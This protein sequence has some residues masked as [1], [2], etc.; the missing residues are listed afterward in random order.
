MQHVEGKALA[1]VGAPRPKAKAV[2][3]PSLRQAARL[4]IVDGRVVER[5][6]SM[7]AAAKAAA[8]AAEAEKA[9][10]KAAAEAAELEAAAAKLKAAELAAAEAA[11]LVQRVQRGRV[12]RKAAQHQRQTYFDQQA[13]ARLLQTTTRA[14][15]VRKMQLR[16]AA[17]AADAASKIQA[18]LFR[19]RYRKQREASLAAA[20]EAK[21]V[22]RARL[23]E[24]AAAVERAR[25]RMASGSQGRHWM[26]NLTHAVGEDDARAKSRGERGRRESSEEPIAHTESPAASHTSSIAILREPAS[27]W[28]RG[29]GSEAHLF[30]VRRHRTAS[31]RPRRLEMNE[32]SEN[33]E[34]EAIEERIRQR[35]AELRWRS[36]NTFAC[37][38]A[39]A[40]AFTLGVTL[41]ALFTSVVYALKFGEATMSQCLIAWALAYGW[42]FAVVQPIQVLI[43]ALAPGLFTNDTRCGRCMLRVKEVY[44]ELLAG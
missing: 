42:T 11:A 13:A 38:Q 19:W 8:E 27:Q 44:N 33:S 39:L 28:Y 2:A 21:A 29:R 20:E 9:A 26:A 35:V 43:L 14:R 31:L 36:A 23:A 15:N 37:R 25:P 17:Q 18:A 6:H 12:G 1:M 16:E 41:L 40:W 30:E 32:S 5:T 7:A 24:H 3:K 4:T 10:A 34:A 22:E